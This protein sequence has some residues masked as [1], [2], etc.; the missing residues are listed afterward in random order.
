MKRTVSI[1]VDLP[2]VK[3]YE[4]ISESEMKLQEEVANG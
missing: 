1:P 3:R 2:Y 4:A